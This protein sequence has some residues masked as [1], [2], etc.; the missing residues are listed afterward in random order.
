ALHDERVDA[1]DRLV[2]AGPAGDDCGLLAIV[3]PP[4]LEDAVEEERY[5]LAPLDRI[6]GRLVFGKRRAGDLLDL[7]RHLLPR[8]AEGR[9]G[10]DPPGE[11]GFEKAARFPE[12]EGCDRI[13]HSGGDWVSGGGW[14]GGHGG[15][16]DGA[17]PLP[18]SRRR[19]DAAGAELLHS[20]LKRV[21][22]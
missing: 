21:L 22:A 10:V 4:L 9:G 12:I 17:R 2:D 1:R 19:L 8:P 15:E 20:R 3:L 18:C 5:Q 14:F 16:G 13:G 7:A 6:D 11:N